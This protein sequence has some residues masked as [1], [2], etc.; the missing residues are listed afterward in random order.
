MTTVSA[1]IA[2]Y[3]RP[4]TCERA[5]LSALRQD[6]APIEVL[7]CDDGSADETP[8]RFRAWEQRDPRVRYIRVEPNRGTPGPAR[9]AGVAAARGDWVAFLDDDDEWLPGKLAAQLEHVA[10]ADVIATNAATTAGDA[11]F[12]DAPAERRPQRR[13]ILE[14]NPVINSSALVRRDDL[15]AAGGFA[16][17]GWA[18]GIEDYAAWLALADRGARFLVLG[19]PWVRYTSHGG[20]RFSASAPLRLDVA[21]ARLAWA[22]AVRHPSDPMLPRAALNRTAAAV[23]AAARRRNR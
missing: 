13:E 3:E 14:A 16:E 1:I 23:R 11:Y 20:D 15:L 2:T 21:I 22:R 7:V 12:P 4:A 9:N 6:P 5:L 8:A 17:Q 19:E 18:R 10:G